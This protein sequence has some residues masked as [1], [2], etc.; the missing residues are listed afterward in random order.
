[1]CQKCQ[2][3]CVAKRHV[4]QSVCW[5]VRVYVCGSVREKLSVRVER[6]IHHH[7]YSKQNNTFMNNEHS[8]YEY[9]FDS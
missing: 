4:C 5:I 6:A 9:V 2:L 8:E 7:R 3:S 1:M